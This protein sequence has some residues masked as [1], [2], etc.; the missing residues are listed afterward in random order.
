MH[1]P[2]AIVHQADFGCCPA[3]PACLTQQATQP[4]A[5]QPPSCPRTWFVE[6]RHQVPPLCCRCGAIHAQ[7]GEGPPGQVILHHIQGPGHGAEQEDL[8][9]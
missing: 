9:G 4:Q 7:A 3:A 5:T 2:L 6:A 8:R 1:R